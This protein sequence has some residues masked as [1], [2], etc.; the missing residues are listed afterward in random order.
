[1]SWRRKREVVIK[2]VG[3]RCHGEERGM[4]YDRRGRGSPEER[5]RKGCRDRRKDKIKAV[6]NMW[7][8]GKER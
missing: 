4:C 6:M 7:W 2:R 1:M 3:G 8:K 5:R